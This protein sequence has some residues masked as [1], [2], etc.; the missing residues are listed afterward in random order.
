VPGDIGYAYDDM[1]ESPQDLETLG[2]EWIEIEGENFGASE[3]DLDSVRY[4][5]Y[6]MKDCVQVHPHFS[7]HCK[8]VPGVGQ[9]HAVFISVRGQQSAPSTVTV[10]ST[11]AARG[12]ISYMPPRLEQMTSLDADGERANPTGFHATEGGVIMVLIGSGFGP[13][14]SG[15]WVSFGQGGGP[16]ASSASDGTAG[17]NGTTDRTTDTE[18]S[19]ARGQTCA[20]VTHVNDTLLFFSTPEGQGSDVAVS[21]VSGSIR[22]SDTLL[23]SYSTPEVL[24]LSVLQREELDELLQDRSESSSG[25]IARQ[26]RQLQ[27]GQSDL[28]LYVSGSNF[29]PAPIV[30]VTDILDE[31]IRRDVFPVEGGFRTHSEALVAV[32]A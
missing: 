24:R 22:S 21:V 11:A 13:A 16:C 7:V 15:T 20:Q 28:F 3:A 6:Q 17:M 12:T 30:A 25:G 10:T 8:T 14:G 27:L 2:T 23:Y 29:G 19:G 5:P 1:D 4:G 9:R 32:Q 26:V 31:S 18:L